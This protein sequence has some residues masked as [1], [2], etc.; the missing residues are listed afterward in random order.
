MP[1]GTVAGVYT[2]TI[3]GTEEKDIGTIVY[4]EP[5]RY[6]Y[7]IRHVTAQAADYIFDQSVYR[8]EIFVTNLWEHIL[9]VQNENGE[10]LSNTELSDYPEIM[11]VPR[12]LIDYEHT[13]TGTGY[14]DTGT[15]TGTGTSTAA[16][17]G[18]KTGYDSNSTLYTILLC[19]SGITLLGSIFIL[20]AKR[21]RRKQS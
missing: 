15:Y 8:L 13:Y 11:N 14:T 17:D 4:S 21:R 19:T 20:A 3:T 6:E 10:K 18:P 1:A 2:F 7:E 12:T 16:H 9:I 5:G